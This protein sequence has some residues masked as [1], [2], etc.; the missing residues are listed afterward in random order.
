VLELIA[1][2][3]PLSIDSFV[4]AAALGVAGVPRA[5]ARRVGLVLAGFE[6]SMPL[7]GLAVGHG[8]GGAAG[9]ITTELAA[10]ILILLGGYLLV[11]GDDDDEQA[12]RLSHAHGVALI[13]LGVAVSIDEL[14]IGVSIGLLDVPPV[15]AVLLIAAQAF[16]AAYLGLRLGVRLGAQLRE[17]AEQAAAVVLIVIG[18]ALLAAELV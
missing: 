5:H 2:I 11:A 8:L 18:S 7:V 16:L 9:S 17:R 13:G 10:V 14:V 15:P 6:A 1:L 4:V 12:V 3:L